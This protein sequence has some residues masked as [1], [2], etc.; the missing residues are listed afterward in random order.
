[1]KPASNP[2]SPQVEIA[3]YFLVFL[4]GFALVQIVW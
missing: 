3:I 2:I 4:I 1:M